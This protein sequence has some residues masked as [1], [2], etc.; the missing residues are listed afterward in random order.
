LDN[1]L[2][3]ILACPSCIGELRYEADRSRLVCGKCRL[4]YAIVDEIPV[5][6]IEEASPLEA[7]WRPES[8]QAL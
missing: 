2:L 4:V 8:G 1:E 7:D 6:L 5:L 3:A